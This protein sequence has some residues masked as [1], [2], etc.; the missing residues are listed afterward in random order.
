MVNCKN[1]ASPQDQSRNLECP[2]ETLITKQNLQRNVKCMVKMQKRS[3]IVKVKAK[4]KIVTQTCQNRAKTEERSK[5]K[6]N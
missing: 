6:Q 2:G 4:R 3:V 1:K 5:A